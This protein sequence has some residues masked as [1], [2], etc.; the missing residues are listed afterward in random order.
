M[1]MTIDAGNT[2][3]AIGVY[4][5]NEFI[6]SFRLTT[7]MT[8]TSDEF[9]MDFYSLLQA[10][11]INPQDVKDV[12]I[13]SVVPN[14]MH[15]LT[16]AIRKYFQVT[17]LIVGPGIKTGLAI[18]IDN[19][20]SLGADR[21]VD[22]VAAYTIYG[23]PVLVIDFGTATTFDF[24]SKDGVFECGVTAPGIAICADAMSAQAAQLPKI[25]IKKP[26]SIMAKNTVTSMQAG[27]V[28]GY[29]GSVE[30]IIQRLK[31]E[32]QQDFQVI[33]TGGLGS[34]ITPETDMIDVYDANLAYKGMKII[35]DKN[36]K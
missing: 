26:A 15:S 34:I 13:S 36:K 25:E 33:A 2:N 32:L 10:K 21:I 18:H 11:G 29:I 9:G 6:T 27:L 3:I 22:A 4:D 31:K 12:M 19:P 24:V 35:Y 7:K 30:Y 23:G 14:I 5:E 17:P 16:N 28:Y 20:K 8:R 1:L